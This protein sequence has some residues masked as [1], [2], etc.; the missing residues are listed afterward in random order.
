MGQPN[1]TSHLTVPSQS[2]T[3]GANCS[4]I[5]LLGVPAVGS[6]STCWGL[7][8]RGWGLLMHAVPTANGKNAEVI[9]SE[10]PF[11]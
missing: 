5:S 6:Q 11:R 4:A 7:G 8:A 2:V 10:T 1:F 3:P 9:A